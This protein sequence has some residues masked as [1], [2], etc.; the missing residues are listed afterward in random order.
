[1]AK[2]NTTSE[3]I[4]FK[5]ARLSFPRLWTPKAFQEGQTPRFEA[6]FLLDPSNKEHA[7]AINMVKSEAKR[8]AEL[9]WG[10]GKIP[11]GVKPCY[12]LADK[13]EVKSEYDGYKGMWYLASNNK[14]R[15]TIVDRRRNP[16]TEKD[17][18]P[19]A[20]C[21]VNASVTLWVQD[22][23]FGKRINANFRAIQ[24]DS[25]GEA[26]GVKPVD[27]EEE[28]DELEDGETPFDDGGG[29]DDDIPS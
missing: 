14:N 20:G 24:F 13:D 25:D 2:V 11:K 15:P 28:F 17:G 9:K 12:G 19:Y 27:A 21:Y 7:V 6:T 4:R 16:L 18:K 3:I 26:F 5:K 10:A 1:M 22:N 29:F 8:I 23:Q